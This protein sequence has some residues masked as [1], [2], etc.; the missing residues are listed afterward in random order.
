MQRALKLARRGL[1]NVAPNPAVGCVIVQDGVLLAEGWT[2]PTGRPHA[3]THALAMIPA[4]TSR[5]NASAYVT[6]EPCAHIG[7]TGPCA[8][9]LIDAGIKRV[10]VAMIDPDPRVSGAGI[11]MLQKAGIEVSVGVCEAE[12][13]LLNRG[14]I[15]KVT[16]NR[17]LVSLKI[18]TSQ[19]GMMR[20]QAG[21]S[22][23][24]T[25]QQAQRRMHL[26]R[27]EHDAILVGRGTYEADNPSLTCRLPAMEK[28][29]PQ[30]FVVSRQ[31]ELALKEGFVQ[32]PHKT[33]QEILAAC[34]NQG[35]TRLMLEGGPQL[36]RAFL[37]AGM[38][39]EIVHFVAPFDL[40]LLPNTH[41]GLTQSD[42]QYM[43]IE[44]LA[45]SPIFIHRTSETCAPDIMHHYRRR[46]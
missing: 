40:P 16:Q 38:V 23:Q 31:A 27:A 36:A 41:D 33:P 8:Q 14:F 24:I 3:E 45:N 12:A 22:P 30:R 11:K 32:L 10:V 26:M 43:G 2:Q 13:A 25:S 20:K 42:L 28:A 39:D 29:S 4:T 46:G 5:Q 18:A 35:I 19:N 21:E 6:L 17:P 7:Q 1:G 9:A 44:N 34:A 15:L 37:D